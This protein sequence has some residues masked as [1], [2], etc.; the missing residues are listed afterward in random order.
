MPDDL[1]GQLETR[2]TALIGSN[3]ELLSAAAAHPNPDGQPPGRNLTADEQARYDTAMTEIRGLNTRLDDLG[4]QATREERARASRAGQEPATVDDGGSGAPTA[5]GMQVTEQLT[6]TQHGPN[7][8]YLDL[9]RAEFNR[10][11]DVAGARERLNRH[12]AELRVE[13]PRRQ[14]RRAQAARERIEGLHTGSRREERALE[15]F[16][17]AG[18]QMFEQR[19]INRTDGT[20]GYF[21]PPLWE[22]DQY[23]MYL[24]AGRVLADQCRSIPLPSGTDSINLPR[25][26]TGTATGVQTADGGSV[27][28]RDLADNFSNALVRTIAGQED[29]A[30]QLLDQSPIAFDQVISQDLMADYAMQLDGQVLLGSGA[31]GQLTGMYSHGTITGGSTE[32]VIVNGVTGTTTAQWVGASSFYAGVGQLMSQISRNRFRPVTA[33]VTNP[34]VWF[35]LATSADT[36]NRPLVVPSIQGPFN[37][38]ASFDTG[39]MAEGPV[40]TILG[41]P[42]YV[43]AN[44]PLTFGGATTNPSMATTSAGHTSPTDGSGSGD[45]FTPVLAAVWD[46]LLIFEGDIRTRVLQEILSGTLQIRFQVYGYVAFMKDRYQDANSRIISYGN[47]NSGT[48][49][50]AALS[51]GSSG[52]LVGF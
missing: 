29:V 28:S 33:V 4:E 2:R 6:Y 27:P 12:A 18:G 41:R 5:T 24:R 22:I 52:G 51:T 39:A 21:V 42:W 31:S 44:I 50:G 32:A 13:L 26:T 7:S 46:D 38:A 15:Q 23:A 48:T 10:G 40:G 1:L 25:I 47:A 9:A 34:A 19:A 11:A 36:N 8:Y 43:D 14:E 37:A 30:I 17:R 3:R 20:G 35:A 45:T 49:A 16:G